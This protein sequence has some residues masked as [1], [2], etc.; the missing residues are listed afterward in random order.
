[1][2]SSK[3]QSE[4]IE[5]E[6]IKRDNNNQSTSFAKLVNDFADNYTESSVSPDK[7]KVSQEINIIKDIDFGTDADFLNLNSIEANSKRKKP[8]K[9]SVNSS[10][11]LPFEGMK[12]LNWKLK[13]EVFIINFPFCS[14]IKSTYKY[15]NS[16][17]I[18]ES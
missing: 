5:V 9:I 16:D 15:S 13:I 14:Y 3:S 10:S 4:I 11:H 6:W 7:P 12:S 18:V 2:N 1:M 17:F 8:I